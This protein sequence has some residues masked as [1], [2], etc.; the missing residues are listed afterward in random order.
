[1]GPWVSRQP[2]RKARQLDEAEVLGPKLL[3][4][5]VQALYTAQN[6]ATLYA[7]LGRMLSLLHGINSSGQMRIISPS[8]SL[9]ISL[10]L[11]QPG[12]FGSGRHISSSAIV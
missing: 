2:V 6:L 8:P 5:Y 3:S 9:Q 1:M 4:T 7:G 11:T 10:K 12:R